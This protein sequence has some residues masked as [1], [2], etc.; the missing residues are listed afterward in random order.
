MPALARRA[1]PTAA[2]W[3]DSEL[4]GRVL[5]RENTA[6]C[7]LIRRYRALIFR[8]IKIA[9]TRYGA[10]LAPADT[11]EIY[12]EVLTGLVRNDMHKLR[13]YDPQKGTKLG[14]WIGLITV[15][16][17][18]D[19]LRRL[20]RAP[21]DDRFG[22]GMELVSE[23][24]RT[25]LDALLDKE[26]WAQLYALLDDFTDKDRQFVEL[27]FGHGMNAC[28]VAKAMSISVKTVYTKK[29]KL[30]AHLR[31]SLAEAKGGS[32]LADLAGL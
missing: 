13:Y 25:P 4:L 5:R 22:A 12:S 24:S 31:R 18:T 2:E 10:E 21:L 6:W 30:R 8:C 26:R 9:I 20:V 15:S 14:S 1:L 16:L 23:N 3:T 29:H 17:T 28:R 19:Y 7:E 11:E 32:A 27:Y